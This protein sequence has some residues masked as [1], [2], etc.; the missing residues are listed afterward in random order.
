MILKT[1]M[2]YR[3][4]NKNPKIW[5]F[6]L[7]GTII[8]SSHRAIINFDG[9]IDLDMWRARST[10]DW[11]FTDTLL[12]L[13]AQLQLC[14]T[15]GDMVI[16]C[17]AREMS[18]YDFDFLHLHNIWYDRVISRPKYCNTKD[19]ILKQS[20]CRYLFNLPQYKKYEKIF[21]DDNEDNLRA[22]KEL[23]ATV[24]HADDWELVA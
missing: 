17:T 21:I 18:K 6:D 5:I 15:N 11:I 19:W 24:Y 7:D 10:K 8:D 20:Q 4:E 2:T 23:G 22:L 14:Y 12:P 1:N 13:F 3:L 9:S 16:I